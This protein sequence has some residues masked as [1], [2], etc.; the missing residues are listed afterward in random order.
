[1][2]ELKGHLYRILWNKIDNSNDYLD[3]GLII[4]DIDD[5]RKTYK[6]KGKIRIEPYPAINDYII[7]NNNGKMYKED[8]YECQRI[9]IELPIKEEYISNKI[10]KLSEKK[11][12]KREAKKI[13]EDNKDIWEK[14]KNKELKIGKIKI[15]KIN[16]IYINFNNEI[17]YKTER[18][19]FKDFLDNSGI[20]LKSN[21]I[22]NLIEKYEKYEIIIEIMTNR[23]IDL[24]DIGGI[25]I[26]TIINIADKLNYK[27]EEKVEIYI[28]NELKNSKNGDTCVEY[29]KLICNILKEV[30]NIFNNLI[31]KEYIDKEIESLIKRDKI[32]RYKEYLYEIS[33]FIRENNVGSYLKYINNDEGY[34]KDYEDSARIF[35]DE[36]EGYS[37]LN[38]EQEN[39]FLSVFRWNINITIG[40]AGTGK[41]EILTRLCKYV[42]T[43]PS[44]SI[45]FL[46]PTGKACDRLSKGFKNKGVNKR[47][48]TIHKYNYYP[49]NHDDEYEYKNEDFD[50]IINNKYKIIVIDEMS[51]VSLDIF[52][53]FIDNIEGI[54][55]CVILLLGDTNQLPSIGIGDV[56]NNLVIS[57]KFNVVELKE[58]YR[59]ESEGL[60]EVQ[61]NI[62]K[63]E[64]LLNNILNN[65]KSFKWIKKNPLNNDIIINELKSFKV[66]PMIITSTNK[67]VEEYQDIIKS[68][69]NKEYEKKEYIKIVKKIYHEDD[70][71]IIKKNDYD[72]SLMNGMIGVIKNII[73]DDKSKKVNHIN[74]LFEGEDNNKSFEGEY[75]D[76]MDIDLGYIITIHKSQGSESDNVIILIDESSKINTI[77]LL[78]TGI[79]R[80]KKRCI[81]ISEERTIK[82]IIEEKRKVKRISN[83]KD[84]C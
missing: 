16:I 58:I 33:I 14:I 11:L 49:H 68:I 47:S 45:L 25:S 71:I 4:K 17:I 83:L 64:P 54:K 66:L 13:I 3:V 22:N 36:Y 26:N 69:Y 27:E 46:T 39:S 1:M 6:I 65:D 73:R 63:C 81:L 57:E 56:L 24:I 35:L 43:E 74:I 31:D 60:L 7:A 8:M 76:R 77:N 20:I 82:G 12:T 15:E 37:K 79:T 30:G 40:V 29:N 41:S 84:F 61:K 5:E 48:Y 72:R 9:R 51:M 59:S 80:A 32:I 55:N 62:L 21:Q 78:Y 38:K 44:I 67:V 75:I 19:K 50:G 23:I 28:I 53:T 10:I 52:N 42:D 70:T 2:K 34:L 18:E